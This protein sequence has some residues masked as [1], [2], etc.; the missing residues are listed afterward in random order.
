MKFA[1]LIYVAIILS[2]SVFSCKKWTDPHSPSDPRIDGRKYC[3]DPD[4][5]NFNWGFPGTPDS[6]TCIYPSDIFS[7][8]Y[9]FVDSIYDLNDILD[10]LN[11]KTSYTLNVYS[12]NKNKFAVLGFC[13][14]NDSLKFTAERTS[15]RALADSNIKINDSTLGYGQL[16]CRMVDTV[17]GFF[18]K[19]QTDS[20][21]QI[22]INLKVVSD[23]GINFHRG[24]AY[25]Q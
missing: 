14:P 18:T 12:I 6:T 7:G 23:T 15:F 24:T 19:S 10:T 21:H 4:A 17:S 11:S 8:S 25:K 13:G 1:S 22:R 20:T 16:F 5:V 9:V 3:N 2:V